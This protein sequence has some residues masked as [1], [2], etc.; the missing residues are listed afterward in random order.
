VPDVI[1]LSPSQFASISPAINVGLSA[2]GQASAT[3]PAVKQMAVTPQTMVQP[4]IAP[5]GDTAAVAPRMQAMFAAEQTAAYGKVESPRR[6][7]LKSLIPASL[8]GFRLTPKPQPMK[9]EDSQVI[10]ENLGDVI[11]DAYTPQPQHIIPSQQVTQQ[12]A[13]SPQYNVPVGTESLYPPMTGRTVLQDQRAMSAQPVMP[14]Q[15]YGQHIYPS[16]QS[17]SAPQPPASQ[18]TVKRLMGK[19]PK[20]W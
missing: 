1:Q 16:S 4:A 5:P 14:G 6:R 17:L 19:L 10:D 13:P 8:A 3:Q 11:P 7:S 20:L 2:A 15:P 18:S 9:V 12:P